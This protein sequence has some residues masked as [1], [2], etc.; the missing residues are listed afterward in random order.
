MYKSERDNRKAASGP[1]ER[2]MPFSMDDHYKGPKMAK[3]DPVGK[4]VYASDA[5]GFDKR[6][7]YADRS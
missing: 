5:Y 7:N 2:E 6:V 1:S 4:Q 3:N